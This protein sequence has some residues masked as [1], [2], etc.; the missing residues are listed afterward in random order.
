MRKKKIS[1]IKILALTLGFISI[2]LGCS[3]T[4]KQVPNANLMPPPFDFVLIDTTNNNTFIINQTQNLKLWY[5][6]NGQLNYIE[7]L[8]I[9][10]TLNSSEYAYYATTVFAPLRSSDNIAKTF[11]LQLDGGNID[12]IFLDVLKLREPVD[13]EYNK[14][15]QVKFNGQVVSLD[16]NHQPALWVFKK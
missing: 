16:L 11:Y 1:S 14:Y 8:K 12:T 6:V 10:P 15:N 13:R 9:K 5:S 2:I 3:K 7:D 4:P